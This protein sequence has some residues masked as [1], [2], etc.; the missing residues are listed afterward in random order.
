M[1]NL[2]SFGSP[3]V[4]LQSFYFQLNNGFFVSTCIQQCVNLAE[5]ELY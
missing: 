3:L 2:L 4:L 1:F 5:I